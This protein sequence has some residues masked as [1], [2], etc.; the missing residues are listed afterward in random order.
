MPCKKHIP[1]SNTKIQ[2]ILKSMELKDNV[3]LEII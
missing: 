1:S 3:K 2:L